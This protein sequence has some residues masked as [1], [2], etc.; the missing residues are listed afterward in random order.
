M[1][2]FLVLSSLISGSSSSSADLGPTRILDLSGFL[3]A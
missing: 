3:Q 1:T 2:A